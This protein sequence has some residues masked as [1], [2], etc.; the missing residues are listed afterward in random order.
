MIHCNRN[1]DRPIMS[2]T[3]DFK[4]K[5]TKVCFNVLGIFG[6][7]WVFY[8][9]REIRV[10]LG[11]LS[12]PLGY[13]ST[14]FST[15]FLNSSALFIVCRTS[16]GREFQMAGPDTEKPRRPN[17]VVS[18]LGTTRSSRLAE[19]R[20]RRPA[21]DETVRQMVARHLIWYGAWQMESTTRFGKILLIQW[22]R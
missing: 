7:F 17:R 12:L 5:S 10:F 2:L 8:Y 19:R 18:A 20:L 22:W 21:L 15:F 4:W 16:N 9:L 3:N 13:F 11:I 1:F 6:Y 14:M